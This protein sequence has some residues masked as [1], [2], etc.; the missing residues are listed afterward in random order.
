DGKAKSNYYKAMSDKKGRGQDYGKP[1]GDKGKKG[2]ES[3]GGRKKGNGNC[4]KCG[5]MGHKFYECLKKEDKF[6]KC[7]KLG[8]KTNACQEK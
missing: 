4:F 1:Y 7:G 8:H 6:F 3:S 5:E 2:V